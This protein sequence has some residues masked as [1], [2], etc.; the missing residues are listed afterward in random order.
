MPPAPGTRTLCATT[1]CPG[2][3][4]D[5]EHS[6]LGL[7]K[8]DY[9]TMIE[10]LGGTT[11]AAAEGGRQRRGTRRG[12]VPAMTRTGVGP[13]ILSLDAVTVGY[14][15]RPVLPRRHVPRPL[16]TSSRGS[17]APPAPARPLCSRTVLGTVDPAKGHSRAEIAE[18]ARC[19]RA[20]ARDRQL[21]LPRHRLRVRV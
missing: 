2:E 7:M 15:A 9:E 11:D 17:S 13:I 6:W 3:P 16:P 14:D 18:L 10:G 21:E 19:L 4:G 5:A 20:P 1:T 12:G 8:Y